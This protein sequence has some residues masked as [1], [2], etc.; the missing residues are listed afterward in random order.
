VTRNPRLD[1]LLIERALHGL[2]DDLAAELRALGGEEDESFDLAAAAVEL[3]HA[4]LRDGQE[5][6]PAALAEKI[7]ASAPIAAGAPAE[8]DGATGAKV[9]ALP[10]P[11]RAASWVAWAAAAACAA[12]A[13]GAWGWAVSRPP[14]V[15]RVEAPP[16]PP[17]PAS[18]APHPKTAADRRLQLLAEFKDAKK[19]EWSTTKD[20]AARAAT[21][22]VVWSASAQQ[23]YMRFVGLDPNDAT[24]MQYQLWIFDKDRDTKYPVDGGVFDVPS[25]GEVVVPVTAKLH[26]DAPTL[27]AVTVERPGGVVVSKRERIV[28]TAAVSP[29]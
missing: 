6:L 26:V 21:G 15:V 16:S 13:V 14:T 29:G 8:P 10:P 11:R 9:I 17:P 19:V 28:V 2:D 27:F 3:A 24:K 25:T 20:P 18:A 5:S 12:L 4:G 1:D 23:G 7:L 22:D